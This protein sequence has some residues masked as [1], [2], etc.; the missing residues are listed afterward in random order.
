MS[1]TIYFPLLTN[2]T[3]AKH[4]FGGLGCSVAVIKEIVDD[5][6]IR[7]LIH[8]SFFFSAEQQLRAGR[9]SFDPVTYLRGV[10]Y[11]PTERNGG[12]RT[13][14]GAEHTNSRLP[15]CH[16]DCPSKYLC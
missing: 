13:K 10:C 14:N 5:E 16:E 8:G 9:S 15:R 2:N 3:V 1:L 4:I 11:R 7:A 6:K 12:G